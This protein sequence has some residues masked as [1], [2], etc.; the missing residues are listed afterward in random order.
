[1]VRS[2]DRTPVRRRAGCAAVRWCPAQAEHEAAP[3]DVLG[4]DADEN[5][6]ALGHLGPRAEVAAGEQA[7]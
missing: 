7:R 5:L 6:L 3:A 1:M 4:F 2:R